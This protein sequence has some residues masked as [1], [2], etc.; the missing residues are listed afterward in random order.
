MAHIINDEWLVES[1]VERGRRSRLD[2]GGELRYQSS[3]GD[4]L[5]DQPPASG[6]DDS[7]EKSTHKRV[8]CFQAS[9]CK[10]LCRDSM[11]AK[12]LENAYVKEKQNYNTVLGIMIL[13][14]DNDVNFDNKSYVLCST[15]ATKMKKNVCALLQVISSHSLSVSLPKIEIKLIERFEKLRRASNEKRKLKHRAQA[16]FKLKEINEK[17]KV[18]S[19]CRSMIIKFLWNI[20]KYFK[21]YHMLKYKTIW[22]NIVSE[23]DAIVEEFMSIVNNAH[24]WKVPISPDELDEQ[25][26]KLIEKFMLQMRQLVKIRMFYLINRKMPT[27]HFGNGGGRPSKSKTA[28]KST[29]ITFLGNSKFRHD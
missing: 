11:I 29:K 13:E 1:S 17:E 25:L 8:S 2:G 3:S 12:A 9:N 5:S 10:M 27:N 26:V 20:E 28:N 23:N 14:S 6:G 24:C 19:C 7:R 4:H 16:Y 21:N 15:F 22:N 18:I